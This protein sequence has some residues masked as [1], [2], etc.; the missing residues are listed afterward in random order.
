M[1]SRSPWPGLAVVLS[2]VVTPAARAA[3]TLLPLRADTPPV[4]DG[5]LDDAIWQQAPKV[6]GFKTWTP[7]FGVDMPD[8]TVV[9]MAYDAENLYFG[10]RSY[11]TEPGRIRASVAARDAVVSD[12]WVCINLDSFGDQQSLYALYVN[13]LGIQA[14]S[15]F[16]AGQEDFG[17]DAVWYSAGRIDDEGY[18]VEVRIPFKSLRYGSG[19]TV[20]M[21]VI[22]ERRVT[23]RSE[24]GTWPPLDPAIGPN[25]LTQNVPL[26]F[27]DIR[28]YTL[29]ELLPD[30]TYNHQ[31][32]R[33]ERGLERIEG[34][35]DFGLTGKYGVTSQ[36]TLDGT[37][38]P[39]FSQVEAD[40]GQVDVNR[41]YALFYP[42]KRPF[43]LEG[44]DSFNFAGA[45]YGPLQSVVHTRTIVNPIAGVKVAGKLA[46]ADSVASIYAVDERPAGEAG[47]NEQRYAQVSVL[48][49]K[50]ALHG[51][52]Y[53][54]GFYTGREQGGAFN[55]VFGADGS[56][57]VTGASA[58]GF[59]AFGSSTRIGEAGDTLDG[60]A[61]L[62]EF[63]HDSRSISVYVGARDV[64]RHFD[65]WTGYL[66]RAGVFG[67]TAA[68]NPRLYPKSAFFRR[69]EPSFVIDQVRDHASGLWEGW[70]QPGLLFVLPRNGRVSV[71]YHWSSEVYL[72]EE[73]DTSG[74]QLLT[75]AQLTRQLT[76][77]GTLNRGRAI[78]YSLDP[79]PGRQTSASATL[80]YQPTEQWLFD[81]RATYAGFTRASD[82]ERIYDYAIYRAKTSFQV[83]KYLFFRGI[84]EYNTYRSQLTTDFLGS[85]TYIPGTVL[86]AGYGSFYEKARWVDDG[87]AP[88]AGLLETRRGF[89]L[90]A[91]YLWRM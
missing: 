88:A 44:R 36:L 84:A 78:Y 25:F 29:L 11:D 2:L 27:S 74:V 57:R 9:F 4:I 41:R 68:I 81:V 65:T 76:V 1:R 31:E 79:F 38:N 75:S 63:A 32:A 83:N 46:P 17:F 19:K 47:A 49:Y 64:S 33:G 23:R 21:G 15:R 35:G 10:F 14:D 5:R 86:H 28:H 30:V 16:A 55:R 12:D 71:S 18:T 62:G 67:A 91:S 6:T 72:D 66:T 56:I 82:D 69:I 39:D 48:R 8:Q 73:F 89:F 52:S 42:E 22:F 43:F 77:R 51:D 37:Y 34:R 3:E 50:H 80:I 13:P 60:H 85:F 90:K 54:G 59:H 40:A 70:N 20:R 26:V 24:Q 53:L 58:V 45:N 61:V 7:D 87:L